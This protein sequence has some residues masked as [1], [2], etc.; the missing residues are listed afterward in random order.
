RLPPGAAAGQR[1]E[2]ATH[3]RPPRH[4]ALAPVPQVQSVR[5]HAAQ[6]AAP[7]GRG[8]WCR[9]GHAMPV[10]NFVRASFYRDSVTLMRL[11]R[12]MEAVAGVTAAAAMMG[13]PHN[14][15]LRSEEHTSELQS[16]SDLVCRLLLVKEKTR[17]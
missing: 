4:R 3:G 7:A 10:F 17:E 5:H 11:A 1:L 15:A 13:T 12:D 6:V 8:P 9:I 14:R 2:Q 16:R